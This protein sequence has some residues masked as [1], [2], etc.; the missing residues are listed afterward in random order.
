[1]SASAIDAAVLRAQD[2]PV[3]YPGTGLSHRPSAHLAVV[4]CM[5]ARLSV[6]DLLGLREGEAHVL[7]NAGGVI[8]DDTLRSLAISQ[9]LLGTTEVMLIHHTGCGMLTFTDDDF[10]DSVE[11]D[12]GA[13]P[14]WT[15]QTFTDL[16]NDVVHSITRVQTEPSLLHRDRVRGFVWNALD[17]TLREVTGD[18]AR[19]ARSRATCSTAVPQQSGP[20]VLRP[21]EPLRCG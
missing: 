17:G 8:T 21:A 3:R 1:M 12:T 18:P 6:Y 4:A 20:P 5:D 16:D 13:R 14:T 10:A 11:R 2:Y 19:P 15:A 7:R 9:Q